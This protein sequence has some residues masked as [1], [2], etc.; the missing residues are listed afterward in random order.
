MKIDKKWWLLIGV[1]S[2]IGILSLFLL[3]RKDTTNSSTIISSTV[4]SSI[5]YSESPEKDEVSAFEKNQKESL[6]LI[7]DFL[8]AYYTYEKVTENETEVLLYTSASMS[9]NIK[10]S[11]KKLRNEKPDQIIGNVRYKAADIYLNQ[12]NDQQFKAIAK[13][14]YEYDILNGSNQTL[15]EGDSMDVVLEIFGERD[16]FNE[17]KVRELY[18]LTIDSH[19]FEF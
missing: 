15:K 10:K 1:L 12:L 9:D 18:N 16:G 13:V 8:R 7:E 4:T 5:E 3:V 11:M 17:Y 14:T 2:C 19:K 6:T